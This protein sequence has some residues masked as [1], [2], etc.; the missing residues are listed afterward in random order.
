LVRN[1]ADHGIEMPDERVAAGKPA[2]GTIV[3]KAYHE[4]GQVII[5]IVDDGGGL[6]TDKIVQKALSKGLITPDQAKS[7]S[8]RKRPTSSFCRDCPRPSR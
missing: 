5:E 3:L 4:A 8:T 7:M 2:M 1:S 6:N